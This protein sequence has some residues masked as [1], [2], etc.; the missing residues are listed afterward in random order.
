MQADFGKVWTTT[1]LAEAPTPLGS[2]VYYLIVKLIIQ[3]PC[4]NEAQTLPVTVEALPR[5]LPGVD[6]IEYLVVDD[7]SNDGTADV[8]RLAGVHHVVRLARHSGLAAGFVTGLETSLK[9]GAD[10]IVNTD[11]DNQ[12]HA[13]DIQRL[14]EPILAGRADLVV[15]DRGV[16]NLPAFSPAKRALQRFGS[17]VIAQASGV[18]TPDATS[19]FRAISR[20]AALRTLVLSE[21]SYTLETLIQAGARRMS[22]EYVP[23]RTNPKTRPSRLMTSL[24][25]YLV[26]SSATILRAYTMYRPLRVFT[27]VGAAMIVVGLLLGARFLYLN[28]IVRSGTGLIQSVILSAALLIVGFQVLLIGLVAD[29]IGFNRKI[30]EEVL[31]RLRR[32]EVDATLQN[33]ADEGAPEPHAAPGV[34]VGRP[35]DSF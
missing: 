22:V 10:V 19:G 21:Y 6:V 14:V 9:L 18:S 2:L 30:L 7:G 3:I 23:V 11:A 26:N 35:P 12:Y 4:Y 15:G 27:A 31:F 16:A 8:A 24:P 17:W 20:Q 1:G 33:S 34:P 28:Y 29:L 13:D 25:Q 5:S 32:L